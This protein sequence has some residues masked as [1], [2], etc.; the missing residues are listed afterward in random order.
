MIPLTQTHFYGG[1]EKGIT[2][3]N[4]WQTCIASLL[5]LP[6]EDVP[7]FVD[8][9]EQ[10][11]QDWWQHTLEWLLYKGYAMYTPDEHPAEG[12]YLVTGKSPRGDYYH[13]VIY[14]GGNMVHDPHPSGAGVLTEEHFAYFREWTN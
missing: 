4:C 14:E 7:H 5:E 6:L 10:G 1:K 13:V 11:G 2:R 3:G 9:D 8:I 12:Y